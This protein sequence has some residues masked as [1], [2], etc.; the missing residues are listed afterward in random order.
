[1]SCNVTGAVSALA[2]LLDNI[3]E[4]ECNFNNVLLK[5]NAYFPRMPANN[6]NGQLLEKQR[7]FRKFFLSLIANKNQRKLYLNNEFN[8]EFGHDFMESVKT[9]T[10]NFLSD[11]ETYLTPPVIDLLLA[12]DDFQNLPVLSPE[13]EMLLDF[14]YD[15][16]NQ[17]NGDEASDGEQEEKTLM[18]KEQ[19]LLHMLDLLCP[20]HPE[21]APS[22][23]RHI[24][25]R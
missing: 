20:L 10:D 3:I 16:K 13:T 18:F 25:T 8:S 12:S 6:G 21:E 14:I 5:L 17:P 2:F 7:K 9:L 23:D 19:D 1:M 24:L 4:L 11:L 22:F 15:V